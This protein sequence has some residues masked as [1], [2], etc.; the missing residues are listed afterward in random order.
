MTVR[1]DGAFVLTRS[2][3]RDFGEIT[4]EIAR[5]I[6]RESGKIRLETGFQQDGRGYGEAHI[7]RP[8]RLRQLRN[9]GFQNARDYIEF[10]AQGFDAIFQGKGNNI[11]LVRTGR[12]ANVAFLALRQSKAD[13]EIYWTVESAF[14]SRKDYLNGKTSL[15][16]KNNAASGDPKAAL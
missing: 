16:R 13:K 8:D 7:E 11:I 4:P 5:A 6:R 15:W 14:I 2:G 10:V 12:N 1:Y 3:S 9:N